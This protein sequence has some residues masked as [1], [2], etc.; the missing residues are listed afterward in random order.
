MIKFKLLLATAA[1]VSISGPAL[2]DKTDRL[3]VDQLRGKIAAARAEAAVAR[4]GGADLDKAETR[5][6]AVRN[7]LDDDDV[8]Q[9]KSLTNEIDALIETARTRARIA[10]VKDDIEAV[11][12]AGMANRENRVASAEAEAAAARA[13]A[14]AARAETARLR[15]SLAEYRMT[16][17][18]LGA[19]LVLQDV[20]FE[21]GQA[22][23]KP[24]AVQRLA[25]LAAY[26]RANPDVRVRIDGHTDAV[27]SD[28][29]NRVL[30]E[31]R[32]QAV[33]AALA[34]VA[35]GRIE[36]VGNGE[37]KPVASNAQSA[38]RQQNRRV[39]ITLVGQR[40]DSM[41]ALN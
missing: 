16:Q 27:G 29:A 10:A 28:T 13:S 18:D 11:T 1:L 12:T 26:L 20:I 33:G 37:A 30:S 5:L 19:T 31:R 3:Y 14:D 2:A 15:A 36:A 7:N 32:A 17:T 4:N 40:A 24:G 8:E 23:L 21:T 35:A 9:V 38:G 39:E 6:V 34:G 41:A 25:P 22:V